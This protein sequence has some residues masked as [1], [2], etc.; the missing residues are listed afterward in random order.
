MKPRVSTE[1]F[2]LAL[3]AAIGSLS[4]AGCGGVTRQGDMDGM[5][6]ATGRTTVGG[7]GPSAGTAVATAGAGG[8]PTPGTAAA[9]GGTQIAASAARDRWTSCISPYP[10]PDDPTYDGF[11]FCI[12]GVVHRAAIRDCPWNID[13]T[14]TINSG[15]PSGECQTPA[16]CNARPHGY[17]T[18]NG[19]AGPTVCAYGCVRDSECDPGSIC[20]CGTTI[21]GGAIGTCV[22]ATCTQD[23]DCPDHLLCA[24][25]DVPV[26]L[27][28]SITTFGCGPQCR[29]DSDCKSIPGAT[30][31]CVQGNCSSGVTCGRPFLVGGA[32]RVAPPDTRVDFL[33]ATTPDVES[34]SAPARLALAAHYTEVALMEHASVAAFARFVLELLSVGAPLDLVEGAGEA[35]R[36][37]L[38][39]T[40]IC[41]G[42]ASAYAGAPMGPGPLDTTGALEP[43]SFEAR[44][45]TAFLEACVGETVAALQAAEA[46]ARATDPAVSSALGRIA[47]DEMRHAALGFRFVRWALGTLSVERRA[48]MGAELLDAVEKERSFDAPAV[49]SCD[50]SSLIAHGLLPDKELRLVR[51]AA[52]DEIVVPCMRAALGKSMAA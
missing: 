22:T 5:G 10:T 27:C 49:A 25:H 40:Q 4:P 18:I 13:P 1:G 19:M 39:H 21:V 8:A 34:L 9:Q 41:F 7:A 17:C 15:F 28:G 42:L 37:E 24:E 43:V 31:R 36:D 29:K 38:R 51:S 2:R 50:Q 35:M 11:E 46:A 32:A 23:A 30:V 47:E 26:A 3:L 44:L 14:A 6:A 20:V 48:A 16:D 45:T 12:G 33:D 52:L